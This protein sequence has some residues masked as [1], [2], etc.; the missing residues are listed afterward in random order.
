MN[1]PVEISR[2]CGGQS[3]MPPVRAALQPDSVP[4]QL[5]ADHVHVGDRVAQFCIDIVAYGGSRVF[6]GFLLLVRGHSGG[7]TEMCLARASIFAPVSW[8]SY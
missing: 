8:R 7:R 6:F 4:S 1:V 3:P 5:T 2:G